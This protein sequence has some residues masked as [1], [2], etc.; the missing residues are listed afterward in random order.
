MF[1]VIREGHMGQL[2]EEVDA[3]W[4]LQGPFLEF[5]PFKPFVWPQFLSDLQTVFSTV[6]R[7]PLCQSYVMKLGRWCFRNIKFVGPKL[8]IIHDEK[9]PKKLAL[10]YTRLQKAQ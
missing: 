8:A 3:H 4:K 5:S 6:N 2:L 7:Q 10:N 1:T 9:K